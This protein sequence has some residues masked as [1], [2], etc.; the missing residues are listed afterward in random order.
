MA[1]LVTNIITFPS[2][3][4]FDKAVE[5]LVNKRG[6]VDFNELIPMPEGLNDTEPCCYT[7]NPSLES[8]AN[9]LEEQYT[10]LNADKLSASEFAEKVTTDKHLVNSIIKEYNIPVSDDLFDRREEVHVKSIVMSFHAYKQ[11]GEVSWYNWRI[12]NWGT[13]WN[14]TN[15]YIDEDALVMEFETAWDAPINIIMELS[16]YCDFTFTYGDED[17]GN[18][19]GKIVIEN[20]EVVSQWTDEDIHTM[21]DPQDYPHLDKWTIRHCFSI[22]LRQDDVES[23]IEDNYPNEDDVETEE[24][25]AIEIRNLVY[26]LS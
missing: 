19:F 20:H 8:I 13:K 21:I 26:N 4:H 15:D 6:K 12:K 9:Q 23:Y 22:A 10:L 17:L 1:N 11:C 2:E 5:L 3:E 14:A 16:K 25:E 18:N 7:F 24:L